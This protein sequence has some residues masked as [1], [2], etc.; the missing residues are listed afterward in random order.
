MRLTAA[1]GGIVRLLRSSF[2]ADGILGRLYNDNGVPI[3]Y[4][5]EHAYAQPDG[6]WAPKLINGAFECERGTHQLHNGIPFETFEV[7]GLAGHTGILFHAG[8]FNKDS[9]GCILLGASI[10]LQ[11]DGTH[12]I[13]KSKLSFD[14]FMRH[15][16]GINEFTL[17]VE[18]ST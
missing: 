6:T 8:N 2:S 14:E 15:L 18:E 9:E 13:T 16:E 3:C 10:T 7:T 1:L 11:D 4:T 12:M 5:L 17:T